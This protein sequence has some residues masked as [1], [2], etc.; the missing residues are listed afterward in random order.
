[1]GS[2]RG[3]VDTIDKP[4]EADEVQGASGAGLYDV[5]D[6][7]LL[8][9][10]FMVFRVRGGDAVGVQVICNVPFKPLR[11]MTR[12]KLD[13]S[14]VR[15]DMLSKANCAT[16]RRPKPGKDSQTLSAIN[17]RRRVARLDELF[18]LPLADGGEDIALLHGRVAELLEGPHELRTQIGADEVDPPHGPQEGHGQ[19]EEGRVG[20][21]NN[22]GAVLDGAGV[23]LRKGS[24]DPFLGP[25]GPAHMRS[26]RPS[27]AHYSFRTPKADAQR[28]LGHVEVLSKERHRI[29]LRSPKGIDR[30]VGVADGE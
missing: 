14:F 25:I 2:L 19:L 21:A 22:G 10:G 8:F 11:L 26:A 16:K 24:Y 27:V 23:P 7:A 18:L 17:S 5:F 29:G 20:T 13:G 15:K 9:E 12:E 28:H 6:V 3:L 30:L 1:M 4:V